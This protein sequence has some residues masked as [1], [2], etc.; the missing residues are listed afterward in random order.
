MWPCEGCARCARCPRD[1]AG[2]LSRP[3]ATSEGGCL[4][5]DAEVSVDLEVHARV[6][7]RV[8]DVVEDAVEDPLVRERRGDQVSAVRDG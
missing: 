3:G 4:Q 6:D 1:G 5:G 7:D 8:Q 2:G